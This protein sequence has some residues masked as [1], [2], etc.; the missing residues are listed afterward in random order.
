MTR[1]ASVTDPRGTVH[2]LAHTFPVQGP[3]GLLVAGK[4]HTEQKCTPSVAEAEVNRNTRRWRALGKV[5]LLQ[6]VIFPDLRSTRTEI[7]A[8]VLKAHSTL[9]HLSDVTWSLPATTI[10]GHQ[11]YQ[12]HEGV[13]ARLSPGSPFLQHQP[14]K[15]AF[16]ET[17]R[18][19]QE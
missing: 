2:T 12:M 15:A 13:K 3:S 5:Q 4:H 11:P 7:T 14:Q 19:S 8:P 1:G 6:K 9:V 16:S 17:Q 10:C 18:K